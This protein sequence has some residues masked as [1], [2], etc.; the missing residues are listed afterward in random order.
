MTHKLTLT[1]RRL[2][3]GL[4]TV[5]VASAGAGLG[6]TAYFSDQETFANNELTAG[7][8]DL[9]LDWQV[10]YTGPNGFEYVTASPDEYRNDPDDPTQLAENPDFFNPFVEGP[11]DV[12][13][14]IF[15]RD[16]L[17][18]MRY[19]VDFDELDA[20]RQATVETQFRSQF[21][22]VP[23]DLVEARPIIDLDD[24]KPGDQGTVSFSLHLF[25][26]PGYIWLNGS[27]TEARENGH[28][29][30]EASDPDTTGAP[31]EVATGLDNDVE[32]LDEI[33]VTV[34]Y[35][36]DGDAEV[37]A[38]EPVLLG[39]NADPTANPTL[40]QVLALLSTGDGIPLAGDGDTGADA[41]GRACFEN[42]TT[43]YVGFR[44]ELP[45]DHANQIQSDGVTF[46]VGFYAEQCRHNDGGGMGAAVAIR[47][48]AAI[49]LAGSETADTGGSP[50]SALGFD[51]ENGLAE[52]IAL[53]SVTVVPADPSLT[54]LSD[55]VADPGSRYGYEVYVDAS[56][57]GYT[58]AAGGVG[59]PGT[60]ALGSDG[61]SDGA[62]QEPILTSGEVADATLTGFRDA[63]GASVD[64][65]GRSVTISLTYR[66][67]TSGTTGTEVV[68]VV[69]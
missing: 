56:T 57:P 63:G 45:V 52:P 62:D 60:I 9:T 64:M 68:T 50:P 58:D 29:E 49:S 51:V 23:Q 28:T 1:R 18:M 40:R 14:P 36:T 69:G 53:T 47:N 39:G 26:N 32:L 13:D 8:F 35:D 34:W 46:D 30:P 37:D 3:A 38:G 54:L 5:G 55:D 66:G 20:D 17:S 2:L 59:L 24:V 33:R 27:L 16:E 44:W 43:Y 41:V 25:D 21:A 12:R 61:Y 15:T 11:D 31:D 6:T 65:S 4:G 19:G 48:A 67:E 7:E 10:T 42:S 22:D